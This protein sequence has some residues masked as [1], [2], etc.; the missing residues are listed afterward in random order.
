MAEIPDEAAP[1]GVPQEVA[2]RGVPQEVALRAGPPK[3]QPPLIVAL[4]IVATGI[5]APIV[6]VREASP[7]PFLTIA[8]VLPAIAGAI[9]LYAAIESRRRYR[10]DR[11]VRARALIGPEG[12]TLLRRKGAAPELHPWAEITRATLLKSELM[13]NLK[14]ED[15][16]RRRR[17]LRFSGL[18]TPFELLS[19]RLEAELQR[20]SAPGNPSGPAN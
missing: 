1:R 11:A 18:E 14:E 16:G 2:L 13:L 20:R 8:A 15:G 9:A 10:E 12:I 17:S 4:L 6:F 5:A 7:S 3:P 19:A